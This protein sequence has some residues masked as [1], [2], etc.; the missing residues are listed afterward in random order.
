MIVSRTVYS[1]GGHS[2]RNIVNLI[3]MILISKNNADGGDIGHKNFY[4]LRR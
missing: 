1:K 2:I 4:H 3:V